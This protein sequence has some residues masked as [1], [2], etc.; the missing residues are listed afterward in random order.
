MGGTFCLVFRLF[1]LLM[2]VRALFGVASDVRYPKKSA[3]HGAVPFAVNGLV[4][5]PRRRHVDHPHWFWLSAMSVRFTS[6]CRKRSPL[7][8]IP[9]RDYKYSPRQP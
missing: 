5:T 3:R 1:P 2:W 7:T 6:I 4:R 8:L 9:E